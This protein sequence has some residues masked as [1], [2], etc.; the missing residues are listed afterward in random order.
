MGSAHVV[1]STA[2]GRTGS[3]AAGIAAAH[4]CTPEVMNAQNLADVA[5]LGVGGIRSMSADHDK[6]CALLSV[7]LAQA[8]PKL[9]TELATL[10]AVV[11]QLQTP[12]LVQLVH[13]STVL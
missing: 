11:C 4:G 3:V 1:G 8:E 9:Q 5:N 10:A 2:G 13:H 12:A 7:G 6:A